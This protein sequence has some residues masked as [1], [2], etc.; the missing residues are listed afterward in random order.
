MNP[1]NIG[2][3]NASMVDALIVGGGPSGLAAAV[4]LRRVGASVVVLERDDE[5][6]GIARH[7]NH[8]GYGLRDLHRVMRGPAYAQTWTR[9]AER[10]GA[11]VRVNATATGWIDGLNVAIAVTSPS[12]HEEIRARTILLATGCRERPRAAR[13][14]PGSRPSGVFT[15][16]SL[17]QLVHLHGAQV[18]RRAVIVG[19]E[20][21][22]YS[23]AMTVAHT[24]ATTVAMVTEQPRSATFA[25][26]DRAARLRY[27]F[28]LLTRSKVVA[29]HGRTRVEGVTV[30]NLVT[31]IDTDI[32]CDAV[33]FTGDWVPDHEFA[34]AGS[35]PITGGFRGPETDEAGRTGRFGVFAAGNVRHGAL[36][37][38][39]C[40]M[41]GRHVAAAMA[42]HLADGVWPSVGVA[43]VAGESI[44]WVSPN[45]MT[46]V[47]EGGGIVAGIRGAP[48]GALVL[49]QGAVETFVSRR[50]E[51]TQGRLAHVAGRYLRDLDPMS[52]P[53]QVAIF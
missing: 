3:R 15:T 33:V 36:A 9:K 48:H 20:H 35:V 8:L 10:A 50:R 32:A 30:R 7:S 17:Q 51:W 25:V 39:A 27:R 37:A 47:A 53:L 16:G 5:P 24:G 52:G 14:V 12:G 46:T 23:A 1:A 11:N 38:D 40:A 43:I 29:I 28:P 44:S 34:R 31:G 13:L 18:L 2:T 41:E 22:S 6:G 19:A 49:R 45:R 21:V 26:A 4:E 42:R